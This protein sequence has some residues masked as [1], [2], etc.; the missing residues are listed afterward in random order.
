[1]IPTINLP[2][3]MGLPETAPLP[4]LPFSYPSFETPRWT[5][6]PPRVP[7]MALP[8]APNA[9]R[10]PAQPPV[11]PM[12]RPQ[13][14]PL[15][16]PGPVQEQELE[17]EEQPAEVTNEE[18]VFIEL[19]VIGQIPVPTKE[20][21]VTAG[22]TAAIAA[23]V[24][25]VAALTAGWLVKFLMKLFKPTIKFVLKKVLKKR[26]KFTENWGRKRLAERLHRHRSDTKD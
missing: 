20:L 19:P 18:T 11:K 12:P 10:A 2:P 24:S 3:N 23:S 26:N 13:P 6:I 8:T 22:S 17:I 4:D 16:A 1:M 14:K 25:V 15:P 5:P 21:M 7:E 9:E